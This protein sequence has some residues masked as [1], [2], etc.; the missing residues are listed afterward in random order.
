MTI[1][2]LVISVISY[3]SQDSYTGISLQCDRILSFFKTSHKTLPYPLFV[4]LA[5]G[6]PLLLPN[7]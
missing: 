4:A 6:V 7:P 1:E 5:T 2:K 3:K